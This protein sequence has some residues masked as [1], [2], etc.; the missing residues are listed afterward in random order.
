MVKSCQRIRAT[1]SFESKEIDRIRWNGIVANRSCPSIGR[2]FVFQGFVVRRRVRIEKKTRV[3]RLGTVVSP[4]L[5]CRSRFSYLTQMWNYNI[6]VQMLDLRSKITNCYEPLLAG[7]SFSQTI[8]KSQT[9]VSG[10]AEGVIDMSL[11]NFK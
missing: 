6:W 8:T 2:R 10:H 9:I 4:L 11:R 5:L 7:S 3:I 1:I